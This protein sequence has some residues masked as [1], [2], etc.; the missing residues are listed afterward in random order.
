MDDEPAVGVGD[1]LAD[2]LEEREPGVAREPAPV[3]IRRQR[4]AVDEL[5]H[6]VR[7]PVGGRARVEQP[8]DAGVVEPGKDLALAAEAGEH[9]VGVHPPLDE[10]QGDL[11]REGAVGAGGAVDHAHPP[12]PEHPLDPVRPDPVSGDEVRLRRGVRLGA[13]GL[14][15][16]RGE[17]GGVLAEGGA[18][19]LVKGDEVGGGAVELGVVAAGGAEAGG[20]LVGGPREGGVGEGVHLGPAFGGEEV[21]G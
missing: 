3:A 8:S 6:E 19:Y 5:H 13:D 7:P 17:A 1:G 2:L 15:Q 21:H 12:P 9:L 18:R 20:A 14:E 10:L 16:V 4:L 11:L